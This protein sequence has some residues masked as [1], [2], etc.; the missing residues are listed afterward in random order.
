[1]KNQF[2]LYLAAILLSC[3]L[4]GCNGC[5]DDEVALPMGEECR[6][7]NSGCKGVQ[8]CDNGYCLC[9]DE[10]RQL[11][12]GFCIQQ[13]EDDG[14]IFVTYDQYPGLL[15]TMIIHLEEEPFDL[16]WAP[17]DPS[18]KAL[19]GS[20]YNRNPYAITIG[21]GYPVINCFWPGDLT[22]PVDSVWIFNTFDTNND[23]N[24]YRREE[25]VCRSKIFRGRFT[26]RDHIEG[27][28][29]VNL[30][31]TRGTTP[32]PIEMDSSVTRFPVTFTRWP[33]N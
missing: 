10:N 30:C 16:T 6:S 32:R 24:R 21:T 2:N 22:T 26:D 31:G 8:L 27:E 19:R 15:D 4:I 9:P 18:Q 23:T 5:E 14:V 33:T 11:A 29:F 1:M 13:E 3:C 12:R 7:S 28:I 20:V 25:W 17:G